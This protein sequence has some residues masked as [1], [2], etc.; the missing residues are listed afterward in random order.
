MIAGISDSSRARGTWYLKGPPWAWQS[1]AQ[2][3]TARHES[4]R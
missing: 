2:H 3:G 1:T 4:K